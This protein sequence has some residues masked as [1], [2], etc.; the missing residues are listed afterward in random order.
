MKTL[1]IEGTQQTPSVKFDSAK[2]FLEIKGSS[3]TENAID[4]YKPLMNYLEIY[5]TKPKAET[6]VN[7]QFEY[8]NNGSSKCILAMFKKLEAINK[9]GNKV[10]VN[11][12][13]KDE[14]MLEAGEDY[15][16]IIN[17]P[18]KMIPIAK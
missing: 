13:Y 11:W 3:I 4:F 2:G 15:Q 6:I 10:L 1:S 9:L 18:F 12:F 7:I 14:D 17:L 16:L 8:L 5:I